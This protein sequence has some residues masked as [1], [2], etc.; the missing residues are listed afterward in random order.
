[1]SG[2]KRSEIVTLALMALTTAFWGGSF[3]AGKISLLEF[4]PMTLTFFRFL[5]AT[6]LILPYMWVTDETRVPRQEDIP[7]LFGL[8]FLGVSGY[9]TF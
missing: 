6:A 5:I 1:M 2:G 8:G 7:V 4:P 9:Y 3:V